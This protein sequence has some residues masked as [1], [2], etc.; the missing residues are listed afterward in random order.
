MRRLHLGGSSTNGLASGTHQHSTGPTSMHI[1]NTTHRARVLRSNS[2]V[3]PCVL[4]RS[5][6][7]AKVRSSTH[8][9]RVAFSEQSDRFPPS[10]IFESSGFGSHQPSRT[11]VRYTSGVRAIWR[12]H[13]KHSSHAEASRVQQIQSSLRSVATDLVRCACSWSTIEGSDG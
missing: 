11:M 13:R 7:L 5:P 1:Q 10:W 8:D 9:P 6:L 4:V 12:R 2:A 3:L